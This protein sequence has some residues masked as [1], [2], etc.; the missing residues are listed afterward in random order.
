MNNQIRKYSKKREA[1]LTA[2]RATKEHPSAELIYSRLKPDYPDLS[3]GTVYRNIAL[4]RENKDLVYVGTVGGQERYDCN[5]QPHP[6][7]IC[8]QC[9]RVIDLGLDFSAAEYYNDIESKTGHKAESI[10]L[11]FTGLCDNC[12]N[13]QHESL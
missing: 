5:V 8:T 13:S 10:S 6:H 3:L 1:I 4:F 12:R 2:F 11:S 7:F 9:N